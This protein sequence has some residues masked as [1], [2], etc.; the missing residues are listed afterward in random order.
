MGRINGADRQEPSVLVEDALQLGGVA[1][2]RERQHE[3]DARLLRRE[4]VP[5]R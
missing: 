4:V 1:R 5:Q 2:A 3:E